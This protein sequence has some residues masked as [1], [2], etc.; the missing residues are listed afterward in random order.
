MPSG[1]G[2]LL[3]TISFFSSGWAATV[4]Y[5]PKAKA[6]FERFQRREDTL[7]LGVCNGCQLLALLGWVGGGEEGAGEIRSEHYITLINKEY[8]HCLG[9]KCRSSEMSYSVTEKK[10]DYFRAK[11]SDCFSS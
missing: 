3:V 2:F 1:A 10:S 5:N 6:E 4:A 11:T 9:S 7:S 8:L